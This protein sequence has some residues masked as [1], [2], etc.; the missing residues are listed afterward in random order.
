MADKAKG[1]GTPPWVVEEMEALEVRRPGVTAIYN[2]LVGR[3]LG[4]TFEKVVAEAKDEWDR[5]NGDV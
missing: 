2:R 5:R 3:M 1:N 4:Y